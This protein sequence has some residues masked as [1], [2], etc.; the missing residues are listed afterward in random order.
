MRA[1]APSMPPH[2]CPRQGRLRP[3][4]RFCAASANGKKMRQSWSAR[5]KATAIGDNS[6]NVRR[7]ED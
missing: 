7:H 2:P 5:R 6:S 4:P 1:I 3:P